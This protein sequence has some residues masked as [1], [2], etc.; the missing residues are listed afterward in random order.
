MMRRLSFW[1][2]TLIG[3]VAVLASI[4]LANVVAGRF[5]PRFDVTTSG[6]HRLSPRAQAVM[7]RFVSPARL[8]VAADLQRVSPEAFRDT[9]DVLDR[10]TQTGK[11][12]VALIDLG[13]PAGQGQYQDIL[14]SLI[15]RDQSELQQQSAA[16][17]AAAG[18]AGEVA[19]W[20]QTALSRSLDELRTL[21]PSGNAPAI[22]QARSALEQRAAAARIAGRDLAAALG[23]AEEPLTARIGELEL[24]ATD[25]AAEI[26]RREIRT[27]ADQLGQIIGEL[28]RLAKDG[29]LGDAFQGRATLTADQA[30]VQRDKLAVLADGLSRFPRPGVLRV[31]TALRQTAAA[32]VV[33]PTGNRLTAVPLDELFPAREIVIASGARADNRR[34]VEEFLTASLASTLLEKP[35][36]AVFMHAEE[37][38]Y[39]TEVPFLARLRDNLLTKGIDIV[40]W[41]V[42]LEAEPGGLA[43]IDS[44]HDRPVVYIALPP[45]STTAARPGEQRGG[46]ERAQRLGAALEKL[47]GENKNILLSLNP[48]IQRTYGDVDP[49]SPVLARFGLQSDSGRPLFSE[50]FEQGKRE[51]ETDRTVVPGARE[52]STVGNPIAGAIRGLP[53]FLP[54]PVS[55]Q[56][57]DTKGHEA[58]RLES[59]LQVAADDSVWAESNWLLVWQTPRSQ[60]S[61]LASPPK[62]DA[63]KDGRGPWDV[64]IAVERPGTPAQRLVVVGSNGWFFDAFTQPTQQVDGRIITP[65]PGNQELFDSS[66]YWLGFA[67]EIIAQSPQASSVPLIGAIN[68]DRL[69]ALRLLII[70]GMPLAVLALGVIHR[71][72]FG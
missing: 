34:R 18:S 51:V 14:A 49:F 6:E 3:L 64:A 21:L 69:L 4:A 1:F 13:S 12:E 65:F 67:D 11:L 15:A 8:I 50:R 38:P 19:A 57:P 58:D 70:L 9:K 10:F 7:S 35:P 71:A 29:E 62:F 27:G 28:R 46:I 17:R 26:L 66:L 37:R 36:I 56:H 30:A 25:R 55:F 16:I 24:P 23:K 52:Q 31:V 47:A 39:I 72:V 33:P 41:S 44:A 61:S 43:R 45:D 42:L 59:L 20:A 48:S 54:W 2:W 63:S 68:P 53:T 32:I 5:A 60:R 40:E 22:Q